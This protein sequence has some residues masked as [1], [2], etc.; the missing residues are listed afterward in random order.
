MPN[1]TCLAGQHSMVEEIRPP[2]GRL[3]VPFGKLKWASLNTLKNSVRKS[4]ERRSLRA[5]VRDTIMVKIDEAR[6]LDDPRRGIPEGE[7]RRNFERA[8]VEPALRSPLAA[9]EI[10]VGDPV[11]PLAARRVGRIARDGRTQ[12]KAALASN[13]GEI[14]HPPIRLA[15]GPC[16]ANRRPLPNGRSHTPAKKTR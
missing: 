4:S 12:G 2:A 8:D 15:S 16:V 1:C 7:A 10:A 9:R 3:M 14:C 11:G 5:N 6:T 13:I